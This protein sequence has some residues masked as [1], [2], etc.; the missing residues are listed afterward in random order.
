MER[1]TLLRSSVDNNEISILAGLLE[2]AGIPVLI[3]HISLPYP[4][5]AET[6]Y[7]DQSAVRKT[8]EFVSGY[9]LMI[10][11][12]YSQQALQLAERASSSGTRTGSSDRILN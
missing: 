3:E 6:G 5:S 8:D 2:D 9:R 7:P 1:Y 10:P 11:S 12:R 4:P